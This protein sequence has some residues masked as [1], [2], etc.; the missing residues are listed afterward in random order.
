MAELLDIS[1]LPIS[2]QQSLKVLD[3]ELEEG[4]ITQKGYDKKRKQ[5]LEPFTGYLSKGEEE[6]KNS[7]RNQSPIPQSIDLIVDDED[8]IGEEFSISIRK[9]AVQAA[10]QALRA[11][12]PISSKRSIPLN[13]ITEAKTDSGENPSVKINPIPVKSPKPRIAQPSIRITRTSS[14]GS[15]DRLVYD[16][17]CVSTALP[18]TITKQSSQLA[19][20]YDVTLIDRFIF[21]N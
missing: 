20:K 21:S 15:D 12:G 7:P 3:D 10:M 19:G 18:N 1:D 8:S 11:N 9:D 2:V 17:G 13:R 6:G 16:E 14:N 5:L 4:D